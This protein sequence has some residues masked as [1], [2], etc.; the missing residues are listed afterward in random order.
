MM[1]VDLH[2]VE[3]WWVRLR[4]NRVSQRQTF[5]DARDRGLFVFPVVFSGGENVTWL[6]HFLLGRECW[7]GLVQNYEHKGLGIRAGKKGLMLF[8]G[9]VAQKPKKTSSVTK[10]HKQQRRARGPV[11]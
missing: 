5:L 2:G 6:L 10:Q 11:G 4:E 1:L 9:V 3:A 8:K 7:T